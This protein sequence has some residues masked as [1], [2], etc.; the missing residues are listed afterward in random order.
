VKFFD[1]LCR[2]LD[3]IEKHLKLIN[4]KLHELQERQLKLMKSDREQSR[5][6]KTQ[7]RLT[8]G[9][10]TVVIIGAL[11]LFNWSPE[12]QKQLRDLAV[13]IISIGAAGVLGT[14][15]MPRESS[16]EEDPD[17]E[18]GSDSQ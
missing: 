5:K 6:L 11:M 14:N 13:S 10:S 2:R 17:D 3:S 1:I 18:S 9:F 16:S 8:L 4:E 15:A 7:Q 12:H